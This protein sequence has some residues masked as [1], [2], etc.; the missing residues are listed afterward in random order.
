MVGTI[1]IAEKV[2][3]SESCVPQLFIKSAAKAGV[4]L[5]A[6]IAKDIIMVTLWVLP[7]KCKAQGNTKEVILCKYSRQVQFTETDCQQ[8]D[9]SI[10]SE[11]AELPATV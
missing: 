4:E 5:S 8:Q 11:H 1:H 6:A 9:L 3:H 2:N 10:T 7:V